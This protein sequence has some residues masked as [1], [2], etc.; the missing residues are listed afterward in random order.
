MV[1]VCR[2]CDRTCYKCGKKGHLAKVCRSKSQSQYP[3]GARSRRPPSQLVCRV[4]DDSEDDSDD[5]SQPV[6]TVRG[7]GDCS[8]PIKVH[9]VVD[10]CSLP[11]EVDTGAS[12]TLFRELWPGRNVNDT[13]VRLQTY[14][15]EPL[16][17]V[18][19]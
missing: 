18:G 12:E 2:F 4:G 11:M 3:A 8:P 5:S 6:L 19:L 16:V 13:S 10:D 7:P 14:S 9:I 1:V 17:V 15:E